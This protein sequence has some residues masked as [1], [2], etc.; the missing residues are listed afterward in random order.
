MGKV[1][2]GV[3]CSVQGCSDKAVVSLASANVA[4]YLSV[5]KSEKKAYLCR[6]HYKQYKKMSKHERELERARFRL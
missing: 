1:A 4:K 6:E 3:S 2:K 5:S